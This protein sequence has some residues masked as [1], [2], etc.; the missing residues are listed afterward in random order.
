MKRRLVRLLLA[1]ALFGFSAAYAQPP[2]PALAALDGAAR[3]AVVHAAAKQL[4][5]GYVF[6]DVG[7]QAAREIEAALTAGSYDALRD[8]IAF[9]ERVTADLTA[10]A[11]DKHL[12]VAAL[13]APAP[14]AVAARPRSE[15][16]IARADRLAG[17]IGYIEIVGFPTPG[18]Y[19]APLDRAM[20]TLANTKA[21]IIDARRND[22]GAGD[23]GPYRG[24]APVAVDRAVFRNAGTD[25]FRTEDFYT[26]PTP[27]S[28]AGK[29]VYVLTSSFTFSGGEALAYALRA[30]HL[31]TI[32]GETTG[33]GANPSIRAPLVP[34]FYMI[35]PVGRSENPTT[36]TS[37]EG[38]GV[39]PDIAVPAADGL[40]VAL[41]Q[42]GQKPKAADVD[43]LSQARLFT[44]RT[45][46]QPGT[47]AAVRR[48]IEELGR[49]EPNYNILTDSTAQ[50]VRAQLA[51]LHDRYTKLG[52]IQAVTFVEVNPFGAD[53]FDVQLANGSVR[54]ALMLTSD[55]K[56]AFRDDT[57]T[58]PPPRTP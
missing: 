1:A 18:A 11:H 8:P 15:G 48:M 21:L 47:D 39:K 33:G 24:A 35:L 9:A 52:S 5:D 31:C 6:P 45:T 26:S 49:G 57:V 46:A 23:V 16:G 32:V 42:L 50:Y 54:V 37:W 25:T 44:P 36:G 53:V 30:L 2:A 4:R 29:P 38:V 12:A 28:Y 34:G 41:Q 13:G 51:A 40:K 14:P 55:G 7:E 10:A 58:T 20:A 27:F 3:A 56:T 19:R 43:S 22:G 17:N